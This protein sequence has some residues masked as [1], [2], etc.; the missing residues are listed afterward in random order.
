MT[1]SWFRPPNRVGPPTGPDRVA[2]VSSSVW[3]PFA[4]CRPRSFG[5]LKTH[6]PALQCERVLNY[7]TLSRYMLNNQQ[8]TEL[9]TDSVCL[10]V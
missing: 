7:D 6:S 10:V 8:S 9:D 3:Q 4:L 2:S 5:D 1:A